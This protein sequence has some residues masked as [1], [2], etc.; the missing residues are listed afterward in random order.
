MGFEIGESVGDYRITGV[1]GA[2]GYGEVY[3]AEHTITKRLEALKALTPGRSHTAEEEQR[4]LREIQLH[5]SL[6]HPNIA[7]VHNA[8]STKLG[9]VLVMELVEGE[10]LEAMLQRGRIPLEAGVDY[11][12]RCS[13]RWDT[14]TRMR[15]CTGM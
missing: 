4:F 12:L 1:L 9:L 5:A 6:A 7:S 2:G 8:F 10:S 3:R 11:I 15:C 13:R 14:R